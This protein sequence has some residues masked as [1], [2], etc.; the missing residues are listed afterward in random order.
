[1]L[2]NISNE[3]TSI[4]KDQEIFHIRSQYFMKKM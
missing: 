2:I 3:D 1:M 4:E